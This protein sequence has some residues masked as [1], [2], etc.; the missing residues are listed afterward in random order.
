MGHIYSQAS[1]PETF[2][3]F[4]MCFKL[5]DGW[6]SVD[7]DQAPRCAPPY[8]VRT[9]CSGLSVCLSEITVF[10]PSYVPYLSRNL[11]RTIFTT[12]LFKRVG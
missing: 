3:Y 10:T 1:P 12:Y 2:C 5:L 8:L 11:T 7:P 4:L 9:V 6:Q